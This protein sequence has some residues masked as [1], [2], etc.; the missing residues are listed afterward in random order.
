[1]W[2]Q[3]KLERELTLCR[4][5]IQ[6]H[7]P[8]SCLDQYTI[9]LISQILSTSCY[10]VAWE[11]D[12]GDDDNC[13]QWTSDLNTIIEIYKLERFKTLPPELQNDG[14]YST[15]HRTY[16]AC[17]VQLNHPPPIPEKLTHLA[18]F[19][20]YRHAGFDLY[21]LPF[22]TPDDVW[23]LDEGQLEVTSVCPTNHRSEWHIARKI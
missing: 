14:Y 1:M 19:H 15:G 8:I 22:M 3:Q 11:H 4:G 2:R 21:Q 9:Q 5:L 10:L 20:V 13:W 7:S 18:W 16:N 23:V 6:T 17:Q 12:D